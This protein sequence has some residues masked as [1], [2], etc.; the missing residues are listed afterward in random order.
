MSTNSRILV[1]PLNWGLGHATRCIPIIRALISS[2]Y[3]P[4][5]ASDGIAL[6]LLRKEFP[7]LKSF[8]LATYDITYTKS[9]KSFKLKLISKSPK[10]LKAIKKEKKQVKQLVSEYDIKGIISDNRLGVRYKNIPSVII[11]HQLSVLSGDTTWISSKLH[12]NYIRKFDACWVPD[13]REE[14]SLSGKLGHLDEY[15]V[16]T[17]YLGILSRFKH[18]RL[19]IKTDLL[20]ILSGPEPQRSILEERLL[21][22]LRSFKGKVL[23]VLGKVEPEQEFFTSCNITV[24]NYMTSEELEKA[25]NSSAMVLSRSGYTTILD[26]AKLRKRAFFIPTPGQYEQEYL[27]RRLDENGIFP[28]CDQDDFSVDQLDR[29]KDYSGFKVLDG[30]SDIQKLFGLFEGK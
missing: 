23:M 24:F 17:H 28:S 30:H 14:P 25:L 6:E 8:E 18:Q 7:R 21:E 5:I 10:I 4:I 26:L 15:A 12:L 13:V 11:T 20:V 27:A 22:E 16:P 1:A 2:G 19:P 9:G 3:E 29:V